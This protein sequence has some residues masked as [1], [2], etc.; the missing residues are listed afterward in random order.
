[1]RESQHKICSLFCVGDTHGLHLIKAFWNQDITVLI[2]YLAKGQTIN[3][4]YTHLCWCNWRTFW[5]KSTMWRSPRGSCSFTTMPQLTGHLEPTRNW[6]LWA[7]SILVTHPVPWIWPCWTTTCSLDWKNNW[8]WMWIVLQ[9]DWLDKIR[10][11]W[12][13]VIE[14]L[15]V[16]HWQSDT[17]FK[18]KIAYA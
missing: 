12:E 17:H 2:D 1:M 11:C 10:H 9:K 16:T 4:E 14:V 5:R 8:K 7:S 15:S 13:W 18:R 6:P 3:A